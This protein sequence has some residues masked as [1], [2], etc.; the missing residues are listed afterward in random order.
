MRSRSI[1]W[2]TARSPKPGKCGT[3]SGS[4]SR[5]E[6]FPPAELGGVGDGPAIPT[7]R[8]S[9][10]YGRRRKLSPKT[11]VGRALSGTALLDAAASGPVTGVDFRL[12]GGTFSNTLLGAA[13]ITPYGWIYN[14][15]TT[16]VA[17]D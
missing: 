16:G 7:R 13:S 10:E 11:L 12:T 2:T 3:P 8:R 14:W 4:C 9:S 5:S 6:W 15:N 1:A 17:T